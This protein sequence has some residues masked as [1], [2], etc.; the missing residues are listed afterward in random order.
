MTY[1]TTF[2]TGPLRGR[3]VTVVAASEFM[4]ATMIAETL[5]QDAMN[6]AAWPVYHDRGTLDMFGA[7]PVVETITLSQALE[8]LKP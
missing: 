8:A 7:A 4:A 2:H 5:G 1:R 3:T 6:C